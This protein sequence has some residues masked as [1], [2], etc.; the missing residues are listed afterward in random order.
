MIKCEKCEAQVPDNA[1]FCPKCGAPI[2]KPAPVETSASASA[3]TNEHAPTAKKTD[4]ATAF[5]KIFWVLFVSLGVT[6]YLLMEVAGMFIL[7]SRGFSIVLAVFAILTAA[8]FC[9]VGIVNKVLSLSADEQ[10]KAK[11]AVRNN[12][13]FAVGIILFVA[14]LLGCIAL[15]AA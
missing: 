2:A 8:G 9:A 5:N 10:Q 6:A 13:C 14:V 3:Q 1:K 7:T 15:F 4:I 12:I 11:H